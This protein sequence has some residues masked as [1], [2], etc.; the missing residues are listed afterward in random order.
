MCTRDVEWRL[1]SA[2]AL[3]SFGKL[4]AVISHLNNENLNLGTDI[5]I[6]DENRVN[7]ISKK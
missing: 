1:V 6:F 3:I 2:P 7:S 5:E 4:S